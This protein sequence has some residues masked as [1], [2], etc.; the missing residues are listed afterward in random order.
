MVHTPNP[1]DCS[2]LQEKDSNAL[3]ALNARVRFP[4]IRPASLDDYPQIAVLQAQYCMDPQPYDQWAQA[5]TDNPVYKQVQ[6]RWP[7]GWVV[8]DGQG[9]V[10]GSFENIPLSYEFQGARLIAAS[11]RAWVVDALYRS[12]SALLLDEFLR[13]PNADLYL[14]TTANAEAYNDFLAFQASRVP[15]GDWDKTELWIIRYQPFLA[16]WLSRKRVPFPLTL[17]YPASVALRLRDRL[18]PKSL[19]RSRHG[20][21]VEQCDGFDSGFDSFWERLRT[22]KSPLLLA[23]RSREV[24][25]WHFRNALLQGR[26]WIGVIHSTGGIAAY[27]IFLKQSTHSQVQRVTLVDFQALDDPMLLLPIIDWALRKGREEGVHVL[28][29]V[30][31]CIGRSI[32]TARAPYQWRRVWSYLY[33]AREDGLAKMLQDPKVWAPSLFDGDASL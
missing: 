26:L 17:S 7:I 25:Q 16:D 24:L 1:L 21:E 18:T 28:E 31:L 22:K 19:P 32:Q 5:W 14:N 27:G 2:L 20:V 11:G 30:G 6:G 4:F 8:E 9:R 33:K 23:V 29:N 12:Y 10:V 13:Q 3:P 15:V